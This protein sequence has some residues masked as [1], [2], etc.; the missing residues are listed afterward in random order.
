V[1]ISLL[2]LISGLYI[3]FFKAPVD[4]Q[5][6]AMV[7]VMYIHVPSAWMSV[8]IYSVMF[9]ASVL[10]LMMRN[11]LFDIIARAAAPIGACFTFA[12]LVT[13][14]L[15]GKPIWGTWWVWDARLTSVFI[16]FLFY[17][18]YLLLQNSS[19]DNNKTSRALAILAIIGFINIPIV[20]FSV[21]FWNT[22]HQPASILRVGGPSIHSSMLTPLLLMF[23]GCLFYFLSFLLIRVQLI[24]IERKINAAQ[25]RN[26]R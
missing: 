6:G 3:G 20:K 1:V 4:Y 9:L 19:E 2:F 13:G 8:M 11:P 14:S 21:N 26:M 12:T 10:F 18:G 5:Q 7:R 24:I 23:G 22:L 15:W 17:V 16:L 25:Y